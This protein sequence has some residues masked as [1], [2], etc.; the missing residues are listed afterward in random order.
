VDVGSSIPNG[1]NNEMNDAASLYGANKSGAPNA[2]INVG[3]GV[4]GQSTLSRKSGKEII[5]Y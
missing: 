5:D 2:W 1:L 3:V 4:N